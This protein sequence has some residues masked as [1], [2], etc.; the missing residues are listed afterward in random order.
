MESLC[1]FGYTIQMEEIH[2]IASEGVI[3]LRLSKIDGL[4]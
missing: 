1:E 2:K 4:C 3:E